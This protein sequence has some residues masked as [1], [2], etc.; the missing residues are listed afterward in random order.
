[1]RRVGVSE[2]GPAVLS[3]HRHGAQLQASQLALSAGGAA[4]VLQC[5]PGLAAQV[6]VGGGGEQGLEVDEVAG[7]AGGYIQ[8]GERQSEGVQGQDVRTHGWCGW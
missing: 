5:A 3:H 1:M 7:P 8:V 4:H 2:P 6:E